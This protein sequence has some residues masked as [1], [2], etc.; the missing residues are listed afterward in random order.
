[1]PI[2]LTSLV[3]GNIVGT[4]KFVTLFTLDMPGWLQSITPS[5][6]RDVRV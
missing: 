4:T 1:V 3:L 5:P 2:F 6:V